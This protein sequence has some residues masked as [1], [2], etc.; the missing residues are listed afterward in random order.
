V[1]I[2]ATTAS[3][4]TVQAN[5]G[6]PIDDY[7]VIK[8]SS[9]SISYGLVK[10]VNNTFVVFSFTP[11]ANDPSVLIAKTY[12]RRNIPSYKAYYFNHTN[13]TLVWSNGSM[14]ISSYLNLV[15]SRTGVLT[16]IELIDDA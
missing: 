15:Y 7:L 12:G 4:S 9:T 11:S 3:F 13:S 6:F 10:T 14:I 1:V 2:G 16:T 8:D 5:L